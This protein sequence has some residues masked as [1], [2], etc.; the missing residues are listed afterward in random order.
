MIPDCLSGL[1]PQNPPPR[2]D[3]PQSSNL[4]FTEK[5]R[6]RLSQPDKLVEQAGAELC[7]GKLNRFKYC[8]IK[9]VTKQV[10][11]NS[12]SEYRQTPGTKRIK[13]QER[14]DI[15]SSSRGHQISSIP[16]LIPGKSVFYQTMSFY[17]KKLSEFSPC[18]R[19]LTLCVPPLCAVLWRHCL[20]NI[21]TPH[22]PSTLKS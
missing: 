16:V 12:S 21:P 13:K 10:H 19:C 15:T 8:I 6:I 11:K 20:H 18:V 5:W 17:F 9:N 14:S 22:L 3:N 2:P 1:Q 4:T 7:K